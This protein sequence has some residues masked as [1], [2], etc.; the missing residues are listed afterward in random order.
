MSRLV[1]VSQRLTVAAYGAVVEFAPWRTRV[2]PFFEAGIGGYLLYLD[3]EKSN[4]FE[5]FH[6]FAATVGGG[7]DIPIREGTAFRVH[8]RD[9]ILTGWER[10]HLN[11]VDP[12]TANTRF[13]DLVPVPPEADSVL[14]NLW[15]S[16][17]FTFAPGA[18][19]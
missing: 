2:T 1:F 10:D 13:P 11:A 12:S 17:G 3:P 7:L 9:L 14:H 8:V 18:A 16:I 6:D 19:R 15:I 4:G 5:K